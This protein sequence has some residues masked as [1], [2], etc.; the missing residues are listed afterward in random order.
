MKAAT[1]A[2]LTTAMQAHISIHAAREGGDSHGRRQAK[3]AGISIHAAREG[4]D[5]E[6]RETLLNR[7]ISIH[8]A[9]E[10]GD[11]FAHKST[12]LTFHFNP[13]RP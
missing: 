4:G 8:A 13:R 9:R 5:T 10:G 1:L 7:L 11:L 2:F 6:A 3:A 12:I